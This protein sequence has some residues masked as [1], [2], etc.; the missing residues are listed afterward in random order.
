M[1]G[2]VLE[3]LNSKKL[4]AFGVGLLLAQAAFFL[5]GGLIAPA[6]TTTEQI[7]MSKCVD[8]ET[9]PG[10]QDKWLYLRPA[11]NASC[12]EL[13]PDSYLSDEKP[14]DVTA[15]QIVFIAQFP[16]Q[17]DG[18]D[19]K[20]TRWFQQLLAVMMLDIKYH[21]T[22]QVKS[23]ALL[24]FDIRLGYRNRGDASDDWKEIAHSRETR[25]LSCTLDAVSTQHANESGSIDDGYYYDC[26]VLPLFTLGSCHHDYYLVNVRIPVD[27]EANINTGI[28]MLQDVWMVEIHQNGGFT[29]VWFA[30]K[31]F[32]FP[33]ALA[34]LVFFWRRVT[35]LQRAPSL[36][37]RTIFALGIVLSLFNFPIEWLSLRYNVSFWL[38]LSDV[39]QGVFYAT[40][41]CFW[42]VFT[43]EHLMDSPHGVSTRS[44]SGA[45][46]AISRYYWPKL[47]LVG[48]TC[49][50]LS[51]FELAE[52]GVQLHNPF[53]S[54]WSH[55]SV[56]RLGYASV[57]IGGLCAAAYFLYLSV[58]V[59]RGLWQI[60][61]KHR[62]LAGLT[63]EQRSYYSSLIYRFAALLV[64]TVLCAALTVIFFIFSQA[65]ED[66]WK[67]GAHSLEYTSAFITG[68][69]G[70]WNAYVISILCL[71]APSHKFR[72]AS[73]QQML[74]HLIL[75]D[76]SQAGL[77]AEEPFNVDSASADLVAQ[78]P[79]KS[80][81]GEVIELCSPGTSTEGG[82]KRIDGFAF[83]KKTAQ[84]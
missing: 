52:R 16:H 83:L 68:V 40:L 54:M 31:T 82:S 18:Y 74:E 67:W 69:Y 11:E 76:A 62:L 33:L 23:D 4:I 29:K 81:P 64:Y 27:F 1:T 53:Y 65:N 70:M 48:G 43:G 58:L 46:L 72:S 26:E 20:M 5:I 51:I 32:L 63:S 84:E 77:V 80:S 57:V 9:T 47:L 60:F 3:T 13:L 39:R 8:R 17:R 41:A 7:L 42:L 28:G 56:A 25:P 6:P 78:R 19:L 35:E 34:A 36:M 79:P 55:P 71:Y 73:G 15:D 45:Y 24:T 14:P 49:T 37:E 50:A 66:Q 59:S 75:S 61:T 10:N 38:I 12:K 30:L 22:S 21:H 2:V 44:P